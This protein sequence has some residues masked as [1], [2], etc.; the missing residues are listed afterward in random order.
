MTGA[1]GRHPAGLHPRPQRPTG[2]PPARLHVRV[3]SPAGWIRSA[4][5]MVWPGRHP[6]AI[7]QSARRRGSPPGPRRPGRP[8]GPRRHRTRRGRGLPGAGRPGAENAAD[9]PV[10]PVQADLT[11][12]RW[13]Y[14]AGIERRAFRRG[15]DSVNSGG[16]ESVSPGVPASGGAP[17]RSCLPDPGTG[18]AG[19]PRRRGSRC[20][21][22]SARPRRHGSCSARGR[23]W[24]GS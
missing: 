1:D 15:A 24:T 8:P 18:S 12:G 17:P 14:S 4:G 7:P 11:S 21:T 20:W 16:P 3:H 6:A 5:R 2:R 9:P 23:G 22:L 13:N 10:A 19:A